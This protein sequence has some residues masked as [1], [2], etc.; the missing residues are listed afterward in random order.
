VSQNSA[1]QAIRPVSVREEEKLNMCYPEQTLHHDDH[2]GT[3]DLLRQSPSSADAVTPAPASYATFMA[4]S[5]HAADPRGRVGI[6]SDGTS[7]C[8]SHDGTQ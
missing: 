3:A 1:I 4:A 6:A 5:R 8:L 7:C 2:R